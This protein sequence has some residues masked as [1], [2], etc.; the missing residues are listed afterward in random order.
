MYLLWI[1][2]FY[3]IVYLRIILVSDQIDAQFLL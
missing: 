2:K 1:T 3:L